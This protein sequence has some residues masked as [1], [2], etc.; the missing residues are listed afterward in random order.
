MG[1]PRIVLCI[2]T[3]DPGPWVEPLVEGIRGQTLQ[4]WRVLIVDS[5]TG[6]E[7]VE[8]FVELGAEIR[9]LPPEGFD[10]GGSRNLAFSVQ[11][12]DAY[13]FLTQDAIPAH[14]EAFERLAGALGEPRVG[15]AYG[16]QLPRPDASPLARAHRTFNYPERSARYRLEDVAR[17]GVRA[18]FCS[19][20]FAIYRREAVAALGGF[21][22]PIVSNEDRW[23][24]ARVLQLGWELAYV[25]EAQVVHSHEHS[26]LA[27]FRRYFDTGAFEAEHAWFRELAGEPTGEGLGMV[28]RQLSA[29]RE[30]GVRFAV[31]RVALHAGAAW[32]GYRA[33]R[34]HRRLPAS[35]RTALGANRAYWRAQGRTASGAEARLGAGAGDRRR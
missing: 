9:R 18:L 31:L 22:S 11:G 33:G 34:A 19:N 7:G 35:L 20:S 25:A 27:Q 6:G 29:L 1:A 12:A 24:A 8:R 28:R 32:L 10:H 16:R 13:L 21:P 15:L 3:R 14:A 30:A 5:S 2:P 26:P 17:E 4:P 23:A